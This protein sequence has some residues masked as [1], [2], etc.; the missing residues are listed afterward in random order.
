MKLRRLIAT[1]VGIITLSGLAF[2]GMESPASADTCNNDRHVTVPGGESWYTLT[3][4]GGN[5][6]VNGRVR[7]TRA[8]GQCARVKALIAGHWFY[9]ARACPSGTTVYFSWHNSGSEAFVYTFTEA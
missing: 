5:I 4:S 8:D 3:C 7:D 9:S 2:F 6:Y 1:A